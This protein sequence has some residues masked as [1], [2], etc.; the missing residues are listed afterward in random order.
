M[1]EVGRVCMK[2]AGRDAGLKCVVVDVLDQNH[3]MIAGATRRRKC[4]ISHLEPLATTVSIKKGASD[5]DLA[6][7]LTKIGV[8]LRSTKP[9]AETKRPTQVRAAERKKLAKELEKK[10]KKKTEKKEVEK[11]EESIEKKVADVLVIFRDALF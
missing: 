2:T 1:I 4:N 6:S 8:T 9:K 7:A 3:V 11:K 5:K 10:V